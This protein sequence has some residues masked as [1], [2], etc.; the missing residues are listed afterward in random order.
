MFKL[1]EH[2]SGSWK[3]IEKE[4]EQS[5]ESRLKCKSISNNRILSYITTGY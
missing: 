4:A 1:A 2:A 5:S 3:H